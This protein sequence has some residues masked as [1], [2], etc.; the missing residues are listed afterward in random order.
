MP[1]VVGRKLVSIGLPCF[2]LKF[3]T[4]AA[5]NL[6]LKRDKRDTRAGGRAGVQADVER[7]PVLDAGLDR[8]GFS[9]RLRAQPLQV[10]HDAAG[11]ARW[12]AVWFGFCEA[13]LSAGRSCAISPG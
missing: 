7:L 2:A 13:S 4:C 10:W 1:I 9:G 12:F 6:P 11:F 3:R 5:R 8:A